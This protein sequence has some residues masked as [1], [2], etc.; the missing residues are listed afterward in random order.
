MVE[1]YFGIDKNSTKGPDITALAIELKTS[2]LK[3][4]K[5]RTR[6]KSKEPLSLNI[7]NYFEEADNTHVRQSSLYKKNKEILFVFYIHD[8]TKPRSEYVV[9]HVFIWKMD[10][11]VLEELND[12]YMK[13]VRKIRLGEAHNIHQKEHTYLTICPKHNGKFKDPDCNKSKRPQP[14]SDAPAEIRAFRL[15]NKYMDIILERHLSALD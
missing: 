6:L 12:D 13:I 1:H 7:I 5:S 4:D 8:K 11:R 9:K 15:K 14:Y 3:Y 2:P 10:E